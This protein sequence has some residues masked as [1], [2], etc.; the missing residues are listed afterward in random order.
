M[1]RACRQPHLE[2]GVSHEVGLILFIYHFFFLS[3]LSSLLNT[4]LCFSV[5][6]LT[7]ADSLIKRSILY[8][9]HPFTYTLLG[10][11]LKQLKVAT[12]LLD[13]NSY[14]ILPSTFYSSSHGPCKNILKLGPDKSN[15]WYTESKARFTH[16]IKMVYTGT[17]AASSDLQC[18]CKLLYKGPYPV[19]WEK[20]L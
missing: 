2:G 17:A 9:Q 14:H 16:T 12:C 20:L 13:L 19:S 10:R 11:G 1:K 6:T 3:H 15:L 5:G 8:A 7:L 18:P 4:T